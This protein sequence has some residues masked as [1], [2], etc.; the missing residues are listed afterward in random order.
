MYFY[1][2]LSIWHTISAPWKDLIYTV[3]VAKDI[4]Q[5][6]LYCSFD[7]FLRNWVLL[8][9]VFLGFEMFSGDQQVPHQRVRM[10]EGNADLEDKGWLKKGQWTS[11]VPLAHLQRMQMAHKGT[12][13]TIRSGLDTAKENSSICLR[14]YTRSDCK[15]CLWIVQ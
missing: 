6:I 12:A 8:A 7:R 4:L 11:M 13:M 9:L 1:R 2:V 15:V 10:P 14:W 3:T 5:A